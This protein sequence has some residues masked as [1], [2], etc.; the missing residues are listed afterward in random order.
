MPDHSF[1]LP[2]TAASPRAARERAAR[3]LEGWGNAESRQA[4]LLLI[5]ELVTNAVVHAGSTVRVDLAVQDGGLVLVK[6]HDESPDQPVGRRQRAD[7][8]GGRG[9]HLVELLASR[10]GVQGDSTGKSVWFEMQADHRS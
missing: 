9:L 10:W 4:V 7:E 1:A 2:P 6:V 8:Q 3:E 5:S